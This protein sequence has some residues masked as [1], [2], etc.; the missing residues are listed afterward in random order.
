MD[1]DRLKASGSFSSIRSAHER[2]STDACSMNWSSPR[3]AASKVFCVL[4]RAD[5]SVAVQ[6]QPMPVTVA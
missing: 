1:T 2:A 6:L 4:G 5:D 3:Q